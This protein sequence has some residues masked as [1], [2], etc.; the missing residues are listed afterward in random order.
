[1]NNQTSTRVDS[2]L[3]QILSKPLYGPKSA[4]IKQINENINRIR[5]SQSMQHYDMITRVVTNLTEPK[6]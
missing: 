2:H 3:R 5:T 6:P 1:M 4:R